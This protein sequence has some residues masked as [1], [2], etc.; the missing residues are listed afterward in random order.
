MVAMMV[1]S[2]L[3]CLSCVA[4][5]VVLSPLCMQAEKLPCARA[6]KQL[7][8]SPALWTAAYVTSPPQA[9][10]S[11]IGNNSLPAKTLLAGSG[12]S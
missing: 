7:L 11:G 9:S 6:G 10:A 2:A 1:A 12:H 8:S 5:H 4:K 3:Q